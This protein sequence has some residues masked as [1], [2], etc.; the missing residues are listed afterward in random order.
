MSSSAFLIAVFEFVL[1]LF[2]LS[3]HECAHAWMASRLGDQTARLQGRVTL[4]PVVHVDPIGTLLFP[5]LVIFGP[6]IGFSFFSGFLIGWAKPTPVITRNFAKITRDD[7]LTTLAGPISNLILVAIAFAILAGMIVVVP[8][9]REI[10]QASVIAAFRPAALPFA[11]PVALLCTLAILINMSLFYF[12]LLPIPPLDGS[13]V[14]RNLLP[15]NAVQSYDRIPI[16]VSY[17]FM[18]FVGGFILR[19]LLEPSLTLLFSPFLSFGR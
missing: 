11:H 18:I 9:G 7:N 17:L 12:N 1:L 8:N 5:A 19:L 6:L 13:R 10:V 14:L 4:N 15:Y 2:S 3:F 16:W